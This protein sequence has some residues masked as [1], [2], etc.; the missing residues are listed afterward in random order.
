VTLSI[1]D[2]EGAE[3]LELGQLIDRFYGYG[4]VSGGT[5]SAGAGDWDV[6]IDPVTVLV[7]ESE[8]TL[9]A[10][11]V[12]LESYV[13]DVNPRKVVI[14]VD[15][16]GSLDVRAGEPESPR[17]EGNTR[18]DTYRPAPPD[19]WEVTSGGVETKIVGTPIAEVW[20]GANADRV[21]EG[22]IRDRRLP[23]RLYLQRAEATKVV[24]DELVDGNGV[25]HSGELADAVDVRSDSDIVSVIN[26]DTDH[27]STASH[28]YYT[29]TDAVAAIEGTVDAANLASQSGGADQFLRSNSDDSVVW[30]DIPNIESPVLDEGTFTHTTGG[31]TTYE[32]TGVSTDQTSVINLEL[33]TN[34]SLSATYKYDYS[35]DLEWDD[36]NGRYDIEVTLNW[37]TD[38]GSNLDIKYV[39]YDV[40]PEV[41]TGRY[42]DN[43]AISAMS[44]ATITPD[45]VDVGV[46]LEL[47]RYGDLSNVNSPTEGDIVCVD[48]SGGSTAGLYM[49]LN[50]SW[51]GPYAPD[52]DLTLSNT[53]IDTNKDWGG[54]SIRNLAAPSNAADAA[55]KSE[56]DS[57]QS[58]LN[59]H[60]NDSN[61]HH[62]RYSNEE[63]RDAVGAMATDG[64][65]YDD[66]NNDLGMNVVANGDVQLSSGEATVD[67]G[68]STTDATFMLA[69]GI[70]DPNADCE[71]A[72]RLFWDDSAGTYKVKI[73]E[74]N[75]TIG[76][77]T[78]NYKIVQV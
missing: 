51:D 75:T 50:G 29:D 11:Q 48:G 45:T 74:Q 55:R 6:D 63:A 16:T 56:V 18:F 46:G 19:F 35:W 49:R 26:N 2:K 43:D 61:A 52:G 76:N 41:V 8:Y 12:S 68:I 73:L 14:F 65:S 70:D 57:V 17:P 20:L 36:T 60:S 42:T 44:G 21:T 33:G 53:S 13:D 7:N 9:G 34:T 30:A 10:D 69:I 28:N 15:D 3:A 4:V 47:P 67:T 31:A 32:I 59:T 38:P 23:S 72:G 22:D 5:P 77:P 54:Y 39:V 37:Q 64:L 1:Q 71:L 27:G 66:G 24:V 58:N 25:S 78:A 40:T 62:N